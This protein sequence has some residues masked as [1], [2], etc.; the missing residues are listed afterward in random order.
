MTGFFPEAWREHAA[1]ALGEMSRVARPGARLILF[2]TMGTCTDVAGP[3]N[4]RLRE[5]YAMLEREHGFSCEVLDTSYAFDSAAD[6]ARV[7]GFFFGE[8][9]AA[10]VLA[11]NNGIV[12]EWTAAFTRTR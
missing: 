1:R 3:P 12:P 10:R 2:E 9:M 11:R 4:E 8:A 7:M 5:L 6:A